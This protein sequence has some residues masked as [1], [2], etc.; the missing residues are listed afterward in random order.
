MNKVTKGQ[1]L[2]GRYTDAEALSLSRSA[3]RCLAWWTAIAGAGLK[4]TK[5][6]ARFYLEGTGEGFPCQPAEYTFYKLY[7]TDPLI[8]NHFSL[9]QFN[10][11]DY[12][13]HYFGG[14]FRFLTDA[15][16]GPANGWA[17][18][19]SA[20]GIVYNG[21]N[22]YKAVDAFL[23]EAQALNKSVDATFSA[24]PGAV[25]P[26][27]ANF[28]HGGGHIYAH[29]EDVDYSDNRWFSA[30]SGNPNLAYN[31]GPNPLYGIS[32]PSFNET[33]LSIADTPFCSAAFDLPTTSIDDLL[34]DPTWRGRQHSALL[35]F[36]YA[37]SAGCWYKTTIQVSIYAPCRP[38]ELG[39]YYD[40]LWN[41]GDQD[42]VYVYDSE[43]SGG[44]P[45]VIPDPDGVVWPRWNGTGFEMRL[46]Q[47]TY[48]FVWLGYGLDQPFYTFF[49]YWFL[50]FQPHVG[51]WASVR[52]VST[53]IL[54]KD[55][56]GPSPD[57]TLVSKP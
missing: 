7:Y 57:F 16:G 13:A 18:A 44:G 23:T 6:E 53:E 37:G 3:R 25:P 31:F 11:G 20:N 38:F 2:S 34:D 40:Y 32:H 33:K 54:G 27:I 39:G 14:A 51:G 8:Y 10:A 5:S 47:K 43:G 30:L 35:P 21:G 48:S 15:L 29:F 9:G 50:P 1:A 55:Y 46:D 28:S 26:L 49:D 56:D 41:A 12:K 17:T 22:A 45:P 19:I 24:T 4:L 52:L 36:S 42:Y